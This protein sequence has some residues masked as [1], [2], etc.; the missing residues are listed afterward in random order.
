MSNRDYSN[1]MA[2]GSALAGAAAKRA[3]NA[4]GRWQEFSGRL[5]SKLVNEE[6][7]RSVTVAYAKALREALKQVAP[8]HPLLNAV[9][10]EKFLNSA[11]TKAFAERGFDYDQ[12]TNQVSPRR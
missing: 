6:V 4:V 10:A 2:A 8:L 1:G 11:R 3:Q 9:E 7:E 12:R 5:E